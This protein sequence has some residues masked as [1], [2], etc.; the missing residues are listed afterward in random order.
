VVRTDWLVS[1]RPVPGTVLFLGYGGNLSEQDPLAF[2]RLRR[3]G[4]SF[5]VKGSYVFRIGG[6]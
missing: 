2:Q 3:T 1:Y 5:F 6:A 4:D